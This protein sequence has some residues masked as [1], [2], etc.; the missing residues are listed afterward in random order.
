MASR[1]HASSAPRERERHDYGALEQRVYGTERKIDDLS[2]QTTRQIDS[3]RTELSAAVDRI[4]TKIDSQQTFALTT[5]RTDW[6]A[7]A[8]AASAVVTVIMAIGAAVIIPTNSNVS[9]QD[10]GLEKIKDTAVTRE[11]L[12]LV[13][14]IGTKRVAGLETRVNTNEI[15][16]AAM[17]GE[18]AERQASYLRD[19][20]VTRAGI[21]EAKAAIRDVDANLIKRPEIEK[22]EN[23]IL[24]KITA[25]EGT[26]N[27]RINS[28]SARS[29]S[30][31]AKIDAMF[32]PSKQ[33]DEIWAMLRE[34][35]MQQQQYFPPVTVSPIAPIGPSK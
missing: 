35:R 23:G 24:A 26:T 12:K 31:D 20:G 11:D 10:I 21:S 28:L 25:S 2:Q 16:I 1:P 4:S 29:N 34:Y 33:M 6:K 14:E 13:L 19:L 17:K 18:L 8:T 3:V 15:D 27:D 9:R 5:G 30:I 22:S 7:F 32:P